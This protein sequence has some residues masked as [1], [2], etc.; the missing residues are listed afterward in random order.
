MSDLGWRFVPRVEVVVLLAA[1]FVGGVSCTVAD[2][3]SLIP[4]GGGI[5]QSYFG[6]HMHRATSTTPWPS[7]PF[8]SW[9]LW[10]AYVAWPSLEP[11]KGK[12]NFSNLDK[13]VA[14]AEQ[15]R[16]SLILPLALS[17]TWASARP[18]EKCSYQPGNA[19]EPRNIEDWRNYVR[20]VATRYKGRIRTYELWNEIN[21]RGFYTGDVQRMVLLARETYEVL[22]QVDPANILVSPSVYGEGRNL[23]WLDRFLAYGG[24]KYIDVIGYHFYVATDAPEKML[25]LI[26]KVKRVIASHGLEQL[27]LWNTEFG[28]LIEAPGIPFDR[29]KAPERWLLLN[30]EQASAYVSR[31]MI[32][33]WAAGIQRSYWY[34]WDNDLMGLWDQKRRV[35][36]PAARGYVRTAMW[37]VGAVMTSCGTD[38]SGVWYCQLSRNQRNAR[39]AWRPDGK[40]DWRLPPDWRV[41]RV[42]YLDAGSHERGQGENTVRI[43]EEPILLVSDGKPW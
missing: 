12:W 5:P 6:I 32:L 14:L 9:R 4:P 21:D 42:E 30:M 10:D 24:G 18:S 29:A 37:L 41:G 27:P 22:K 11:E 36:K 39:V 19:A 43:G 1:L 13:Y 35:M 25:P 3:I 7:A 15:H 33:G 34:S 40:R 28:W 38:P 31:A 26:S 2:E 20:T 8:G 16:V 23:E 17:P